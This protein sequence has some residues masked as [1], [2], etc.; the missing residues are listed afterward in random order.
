MPKGNPQVGELWRR[1]NALGSIPDDGEMRDL[2]AA[3]HEELSPEGRKRL[4]RL[5]AGV[6]H[7]CAPGSSGPIRIILEALMPGESEAAP[8]VV[9]GWPPGCARRSS[10]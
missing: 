2:C 10:R 7:L 6:A 5:M 1:N 4:L 8:P 3:L 9:I